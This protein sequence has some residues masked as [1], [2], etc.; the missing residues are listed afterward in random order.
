MDT[1]VV[2]STENSLEPTAIIR[3]TGAAIAFCRDYVVRD[4]AKGDQTG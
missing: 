4:S 3:M 2:R 1:Y